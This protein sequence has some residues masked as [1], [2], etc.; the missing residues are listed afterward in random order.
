V[1]NNREKRPTTA[2]IVDKLNKTETSKI[3]SA[4]EVM[5]IVIGVSVFLTKLVRGINYVI[6]YIISSLT[7]DKD[8]LEYPIG[9]AATTDCYGVILFRGVGVLLLEEYMSISHILI[10]L[11]SWTTGFYLLYFSV[12]CL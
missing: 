9:G 10:Q 2:E 3:S 4:C 11:N 7:H 12:Y 1:D 8:I 5:Y 6:N